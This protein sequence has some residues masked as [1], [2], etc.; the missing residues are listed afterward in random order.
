MTTP[1]PTP[2]L[3]LVQLIRDARR[4]ALTTTPTALWA[5]DLIGL[6]DQARQVVNLLDEWIA[7]RR[8]AARARPLA[9][10]LADAGIPVPARPQTGDPG[11]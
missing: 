1:E 3:D 4:A 6:R 8:V 10:R 11:E 9:E 7:E 2:E 5:V